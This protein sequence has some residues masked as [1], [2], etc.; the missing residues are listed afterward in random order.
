M[1]FVEQIP[2]ILTF[3]LI[4][5]LSFGDL[6]VGLGIIYILGRLVYTFSYKLLGPNFRYPGAVAAG[7]SIFVLWAFCVGA[8]FSVLTRD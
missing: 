5:G 6:V 2:L 4:A 8:T 3:L 1:N 7:L